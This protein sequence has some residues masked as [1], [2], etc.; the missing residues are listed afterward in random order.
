MNEDVD[1][2]GVEHGVEDDQHSEPNIHGTTRERDQKYREWINLCDRATM[3]L[4]R[5]IL[6]F[7]AN[8]NPTYSKSTK[9]SS[10]KHKNPLTSNN[11]HPQNKINERLLKSVDFLNPPNPKNLSDPRIIDYTVNERLFPEPVLGYNGFSLD[12]NS[13][14]NR[15]EFVEHFG[16]PNEVNSPKLA[17]KG[18]KGTMGCSQYASPN[19]DTKY[20][21]LNFPRH[22]INHE[23]C[24]VVRNNKPEILIRTEKDLACSYSL[25]ANSKNSVKN[26]GTGFKIF[27]SKNFAPR[28][29]NTL[30]LT[31]AFRENVYS[32]MRNV[33]EEADEL[34]RQLNDSELALREKNFYKKSVEAMDWINRSRHDNLETDLEVNSSPYVI[35]NTKSEN[36]FDR[37][38]YFSKGNRP[39]SLRKGGDCSVSRKL[40][41]INRI[42]PKKSVG[43]VGD[44]SINKSGSTEYETVDGAESIFE[45]E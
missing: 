1:A 29:K 41:Y 6:D 13:G 36:S 28:N 39:T 44:A 5:N 15:N 16:T 2:E 17:K 7:D 4:N 14:M 12:E 43:F 25:L 33:N 3:A 32:K 45:L 30:D 35:R 37:R 27:K 11:G 18:Q 20:I 19:I 38:D 42:S 26:A 24:S 8:N 23:S 31:S 40:D 34:I 21:R 22:R 9:A 10:Y